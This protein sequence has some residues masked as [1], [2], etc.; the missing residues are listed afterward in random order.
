MSQH[1]VRTTEKRAVLIIHVNKVTNK[2]YK[3]CVINIIIMV[4]KNRQS[5]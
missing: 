3:Y 4:F 5:Q 2:K 1:P